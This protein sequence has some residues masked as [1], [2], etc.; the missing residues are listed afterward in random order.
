[1]MKGTLAK[2]STFL[3]TLILHVNLIFAQGVEENT[4]KEDLLHNSC[5][6]LGN[7]AVPDSLLR[8][9]S[10][11]LVEFD[12]YSVAQLHHDM[13]SVGT[14]AARDLYFDQKEIKI[15]VIMTGLD[16][17]I[18]HLNTPIHKEGNRSHIS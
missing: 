8:N 17:G 15:P 13:I 2:L 12:N 18:A 3:L 10:F 9:D 4:E 11:E 5:S 1:M 14:V 16:Q 6:T 7:T